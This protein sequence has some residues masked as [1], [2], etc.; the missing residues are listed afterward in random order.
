MLIAREAHA[1]G[2][3]DEIVR[4]SHKAGMAPRIVPR[5][6]LDRL[7]PGNHQGV[8]VVARP[9]RYSSLE[10]LLSAAAVGLLFADGIMDPQN[11]GSLL[12]SALGAGFNGVVIPS[13]RAAGVTPAVRRV[14]A[15]AAELLGVARVTNLA[16]AI[17]DAKSS[18]LWVVGMDQAAEDVMWTSDLMNPPVALVVGAEDRGISRIVRQRCDGLVRIPQQGRLGSLNAGVAGALGMFEVARRVSA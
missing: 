9:Y 15:G 16:R 17:E 14:S 10:S 5:A 11:L 4:R 7:A 3:L 1:S 2:L 6:E 8:V 18:G 13:H 12:R